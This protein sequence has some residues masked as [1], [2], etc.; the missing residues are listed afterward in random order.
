MPNRGAKLPALVGV[1]HCILERRRSDSRGHRRNSQPAPIER[2][3]GINQTHRGVTQQLCVRDEE[4]VKG[5]SHGL[6]S[7]LPHLVFLFP[8]DITICVRGNNEAAYPPG[9]PAVFPR[10]RSAHREH[11][12]TEAAIGDPCFG[13]VEHPP[14]LHARRLCSE[15]CGIR[16]GIRFGQGERAE[17]LPP[18]HGL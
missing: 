6:R 16:T 5:N 15:G 8:Q 4:I 18:C 12:I 14:P 11:H 3:K 7:A 2:P 17:Q 10:V 9:T 13:A 1:A